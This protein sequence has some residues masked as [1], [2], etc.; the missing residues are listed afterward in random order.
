MYDVAKDFAGPIATIIVA[1]A[2]G[3]ITW[4][5]NRRQTVIAA[6][7][8]KFDLFEKRYE[9]YRTALKM[10]E[11]VIA[12]GWKLDFDDLRTQSIRL[13]E[14][15]FFFDKEITDFLDKLC[16]QA[17]MCYKI[18]SDA[19]H[20]AASKEQEAEENGKLAG[21]Y[22]WIPKIFEEALKFRQLTE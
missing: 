14:A 13:E 10:A 12:E 11:D 8:L 22:A 15:K 9:V 6:D 1:V 4:T 2:A 21:M 5:Y 19:T 17:L 20:G 7:K 3:W 18:S 16:T